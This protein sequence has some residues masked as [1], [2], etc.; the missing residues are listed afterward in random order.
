MAK[1]CGELPCQPIFHFILQPIAKACA[2][3]AFAG[4]RADARAKS[5]RYKRN[6]DSF[7]A[8]SKHTGI[9]KRVR[10]KQAG[11]GEGTSINTRAPAK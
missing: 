2:A 8:S 11:A 5:N 10:V 9:S 3:G 4:A 6:G 7:A 1:P